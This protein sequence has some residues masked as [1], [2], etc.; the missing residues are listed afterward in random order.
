MLT[1][2]STSTSFMVAGVPLAPDSA[3]VDAG[4]DLRL[5]PQATIGVSY[6]GQLAGHAQDHA[7][8]GKFAWDY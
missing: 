4:F 6:V 2:L 1:F 7:L 5:R 8:K 3:L